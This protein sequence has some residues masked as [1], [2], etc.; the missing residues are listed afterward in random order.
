MV[1]LLASSDS[2]T[3][4]SIGERKAIDI[5][6]SALT[7]CDEPIA[8]G[9]GDDCAAVKIGKDYLL[10]TTDMI[11]QKRHFPPEISPYQMGWHVVAISLSDLAAKGARPLG[12]VVAAGVPEDYN[13]R[14][15]KEL[16]K[17]MNKCATKHGTAIIGGDMKSH[18]H[19]TLTS[20]AIGKVPQKDFMSRLGARPGDI[21]GITGALGRAGAAYYALK[22]D[23]VKKFKGVATGLFE[24]MPRLNEGSAL[25]KSGVVSSS[26]DI[27][28]GLANSLYQLS[29]LTKL[30]F[31]VVFDNIPLDPNATKLAEK[32]DM[33]IEDLTIYFGGDYEL[34]VTV[35][36]KGWDKAAD[37]VKKAGGQL[38]QV[39]FV[40][41]KRRMNLIK[42]G[43]KSHLEN[44][45][46]EHFKWED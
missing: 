11:T 22:N 31:D 30:S 39:G 29:S 23:L 19:L 17:G 25:A 4:R 24:P 2:R 6:L 15:L 16:V 43:T 33:P 28:D 36:S 14:F 32:L 34:L 21:I 45:G 10:I 9:P 1:I 44:R 42:D 5:I 46:Y 40:T 27:S 13:V 12:V 41:G 20:T 38:T 26:M 18:D 3:L 35:T 8:V 7:A 37:A